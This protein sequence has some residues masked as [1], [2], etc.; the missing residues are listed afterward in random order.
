M[1]CGASAGDEGWGARRGSGPA[2][3]AA[4]ASSGAGWAGG[5]RRAGGWGGAGA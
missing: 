5:V 2:P 4:R 1:N 3:G